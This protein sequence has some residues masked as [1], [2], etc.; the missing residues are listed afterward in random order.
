[1]QAHA[2]ARRGSEAR[3]TADKALGLL[4]DD[5]PVGVA[6]DQRLHGS[7]VPAHADAAT[8]VDGVHGLRLRQAAFRGRRSWDGGSFPN[9]A[10]RRWA[11]T[12][13]AAG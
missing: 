4:R 3:D 7:V 8:V 12:W 1:M 9:L 10:A 11:A 5:A 6:P 13:R 2:N